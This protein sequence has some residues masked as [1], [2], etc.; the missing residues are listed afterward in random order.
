MSGTTLCI[1][2]AAKGTRSTF[3]VETTGMLDCSSMAILIAGFMGEVV[4]GSCK[5]DRLLHLTTHG[6]HR[7]PLVLVCDARSVFD[8]L[9]AVEVRVPAD[10]HLLYHLMKLREWVDAGI[11]KQLAWTDTRDMICDGLTKGAPSRIPLLTLQETG[12]WK[13]QHPVVMWPTDK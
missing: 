7:L 9:T 3:A 11:I 4:C 8:A 6:G 1:T 2:K 10:P 13:V 12:T 5:P